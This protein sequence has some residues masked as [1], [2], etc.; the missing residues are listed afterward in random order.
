MLIK[1]PCLIMLLTEK[2]HALNMQQLVWCLSHL[3]CIIFIILT[4]IMNFAVVVFEFNLS[5]IF[6]YGIFVIGK[7]VK[8]KQQNLN[9]MLLYFINNYFYHN[10][11][12]IL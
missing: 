9:K 1:I 2:N 4:F 7:F 8:K 11:Y 6:F 12:T 5:I 3:H 10:T